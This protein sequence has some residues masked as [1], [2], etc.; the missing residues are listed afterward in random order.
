[1]SIVFELFD[2]MYDRVVSNTFKAN[3]LADVLFASIVDM[4]ADVND[5]V[6]VLKSKL[7]PVW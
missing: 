7:V 6:V 5:A 1:M 2:A 4:P 3:T